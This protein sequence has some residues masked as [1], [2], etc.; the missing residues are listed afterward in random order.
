MLKEVPRVA[1]IVSMSCSKKQEFLWAG[2]KD[3]QQKLEDIT[4]S[5]GRATNVKKLQTELCYSGFVIEFWK[6]KDAAAS[7]EASME[8]GKKKIL[9]DPI[10]TVFF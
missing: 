9:C 1:P 6:E 10:N 7:K 8:F 5:S 2:P 4:E 3:R